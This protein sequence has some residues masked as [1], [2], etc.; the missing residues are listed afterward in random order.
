MADVHLLLQMIKSK[1]RDVI[2]QWKFRDTYQT[3]CEN[4]K[5]LPSHSPYRTASLRTIERPHVNN[6]LN[7]N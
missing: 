6:N 2:I 3:L 4:V 7:T 1:L 5:N